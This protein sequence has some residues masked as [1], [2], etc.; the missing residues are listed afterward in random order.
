MRS[1]IDSAGGMVEASDGTSGRTSAVIDCR[2][3]LCDEVSLEVKMVQ[4]VNE[5]SSAAVL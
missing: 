4:G 2:C 1:E 5:F 3:V